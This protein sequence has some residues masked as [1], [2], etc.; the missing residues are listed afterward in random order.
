[1]LS[2]P[3]IRL[4]WGAYSSTALMKQCHLVLTP[5]GAM[6]RASKGKGSKDWCPLTWDLRVWDDSIDPR[7]EQTRRKSYPMRR[8][9]AAD[10][11]EL[12]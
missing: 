3:E 4:G 11:M 9:R 5:D 6:V 2:R 7:Y 1:M 8:E 12:T 10:V